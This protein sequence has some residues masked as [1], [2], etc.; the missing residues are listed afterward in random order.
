LKSIQKCRIGA[1]LFC[2]TIPSRYTP[3][4]RSIF[5]GAD[6]RAEN[7]ED[8]PCAPAQTRPAQLIAAA[9]MPALMTMSPSPLVVGRHGR[10]EGAEAQPLLDRYPPPYARTGDRQ[11]S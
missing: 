9:N 10:T 5:G 1:P 3:P 2:T 11:R 8:A 4:T 6:T 7:P